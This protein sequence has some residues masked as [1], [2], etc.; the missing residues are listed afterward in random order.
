MEQYKYDQG[1]D[2]FHI[3]VTTQIRLEMAGVVDG[4]VDWAGLRHC[5]PFWELIYINGGQGEIKLNNSVLPCAKQDLFL[6]PPLEIHQFLNRGRDLLEIFYIGFGSESR[7]LGDYDA[8]ATP[9]LKLPSAREM[10]MDKLG[11]LVDSIKTAKSGARTYQDQALLFEIIYKLM[12]FIQK[13]PELIR[14]HPADRNAVFA[15]RAMRYI[16]SNI[17]RTI[18]VEEVA[19][20]FFLSPH[21]FAKKFKDQAGFGIKEYHNRARMLKALDLLGDP[22]LSVSEAAEKL[23]YE[24]V[25]YFTNR[26]REFHGLSPTEYRRRQASAKPRAAARRDTVLSGNTSGTGPVLS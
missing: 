22:L 3:D 26:F 8:D 25:T 15:D 11:L 10:L 19:A 9:V 17:H 21:Y 2:R 6:I 12:D 4:P 5:H 20:R 16:E 18:K 13:H 23:G 24:H 7:A 14:D 1:D